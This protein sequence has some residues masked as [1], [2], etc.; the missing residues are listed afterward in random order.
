MARIA[1][2]NVSVSWV[3]SAFLMTQRVRIDDLG[4]ALNVVDL[5]MLDELSRPAREPL[6]DVVLELT[7]LAEIDLGFTELDAPGFR[8]SGFIDQLR[9][10]QKGFRRNAPSID[11]DAARIHFRID[12]DDAQT[13]VRGEKGSC[14]AT[15]ATAHHDKLS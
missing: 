2:S 1:C 14:I 10:V 8:V 5:A 12:Q 4:E 6:D 13:E 7:Q 9:D 3:P 11:A 15:R